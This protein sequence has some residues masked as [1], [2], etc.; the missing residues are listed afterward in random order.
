M[1]LG[2]TAD[3]LLLGGGKGGIDAMLGTGVFRSHVSSIATLGHGLQI[4]AQYQIGL[5]PDDRTKPIKAR[6][7]LE[8][9]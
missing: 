5:I 3:L 4:I 6:H 7:V 1:C 8:G 2:M 9:F